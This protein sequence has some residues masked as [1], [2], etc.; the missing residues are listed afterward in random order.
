MLTPEQQSRLAELRAKRDGGAS[1][2]P[3]ARV[4]ETKEEK[5]ESKVSLFEALFPRVTSRNPREEGQGIIAN[6]ILDVLSIPGRALGSGAVSKG[7]TQPEQVK[8]QMT[9]IEGQGVFQNIL[10]DPATIPSVAVGGPAMSAGRAVAAKTL[11]K[12]AQALGGVSAGSGVMGATSAGVHQAERSAGGGGVSPSDAAMETAI[13]AAVPGGIAGLG[14]ILGVSREAARSLVSTLAGPKAE[15]LERFGW[16][17]GKGAKG[18]KEAAAVGNVEYGR[19]LDDAVQN[20]S[21]NLPEKQVVDKA[22]AT[23]PKI[24]LMPALNVL[25]KSRNEL[26]TESGIILPAGEQAA[27]KIDKLI[28]SMKVNRGGRAAPGQAFKT[29][30]DAEEYLNLRRKLDEALPE[31]DAVDFNIVQKAVLD[32][33]TQMKKALEE[34]APP[35]YRDAM[36]SWAEKLDLAE[37]LRQIVTGKGNDVTKHERAT[38]FFASLFDETPSAEIR[39]DLIRQMDA[40]KGTNFL[41]MAENAHH[42]KAF[43]DMGAGSVLPQ[44]V[45]GK[46]LIASALGANV[47]G[48]GGLKELL[49][50]MAILSTERGGAAA[51]GTLKGAATAA[52]KAKPAIAEATRAGVRG[53]FVPEQKEKGIFEML[54]AQ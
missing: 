21:K 38:K 45:W 42:A 46:T 30:F 47:L 13:S 15:T 43:G 31:K 29:K 7:F 40:A 11:P 44:T 14:K 10:R 48:V 3:S 27:A 1:P 50:P 34:S 26:S 16:G 19:R 20:F 12:A 37:D 22:V 33:R 4:A 54:G 28:S 36:R 18:M 5:P 23:M 9:D 32:A 52:T 8:E 2:I 53:S 41:E 49:I 6:P 35:E 51:L 39:R 25:Q 24:D 17:F